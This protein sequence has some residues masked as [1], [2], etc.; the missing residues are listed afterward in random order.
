MD[1]HTPHA[2]AP[3]HANDGGPETSETGLRPPPASLEAEQAFLGAL[4]TNNKV[5]EKVGEFLRPE[6]FIHPAHAL[7]YDTCQRLIERNQ[8][9]NPVTVKPYVDSDEAL[10]EVGGARYLAALVGSVVSVITRRITAVSSTTIICGASSSRWA[11]TW[12]TRRTPTIST[13]APPT[14]SRP[15]SSAFTT[16]PPA[17]N[18]RAVC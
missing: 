16:W 2:R 4:L 13:S 18:T 12:S 9:A 10:A 14:R 17:A 3:S 15:A 5:L 7:I 6:H 8:V 1:S 11:P